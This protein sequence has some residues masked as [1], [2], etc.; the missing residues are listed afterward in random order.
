MDTTEKKEVR[1]ADLG[2]PNCTWKAEAK[3]ENEALRQ[4]EQHGREHHGMREI[5]S[6]L[7]EK[8]RNLFRRAA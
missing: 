6:A 4:V 5:P 2:D 7:K 3:D 8:V 1:C